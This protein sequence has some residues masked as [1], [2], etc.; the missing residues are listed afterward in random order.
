MYNVWQDCKKF[1]SDLVELMGIVEETM[2]IDEAN[3]SMDQL[4]ARFEARIEERIRHVQNSIEDI[5]LCTREQYQTAEDQTSA[6]KQTLKSMCVP[7]VGPGSCLC[8]V[9]VARVTAQRDRIAGWSILVP[10]LRSKYQKH[11]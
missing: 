4:E 8:F 11:G 6:L 10:S 3:E 1:A 2:P 5:N 7:L 9:R